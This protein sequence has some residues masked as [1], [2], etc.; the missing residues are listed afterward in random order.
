MTDYECT[1]YDTEYGWEPIQ[2]ISAFHAAEAYAK[3]ADDVDCC[4]VNNHFVLVKKQGASD[5]EAK[6]YIVTG[7]Q[8]IIYFAEEC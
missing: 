8:K 2:A 3:W 1:E 5:D 4:G 7:Q 6:K